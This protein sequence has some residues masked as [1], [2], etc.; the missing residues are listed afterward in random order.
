MMG[1]VLGVNGING[2][3]EL[4]HKTGEPFNFFMAFSLTTSI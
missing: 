4:G 2:S 1:T 3:H